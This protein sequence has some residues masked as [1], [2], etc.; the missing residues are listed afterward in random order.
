ML[1]ETLELTQS[2]VKTHQVEKKRQSKLH[3]IETPRR[4]DLVGC[5]SQFKTK[6]KRR[7]AKPDFRGREQIRSDM[8]V[9]PLIK[10]HERLAIRNYMDRQLGG[11][12]S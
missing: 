4:G 9:Y 5:I 6:D 3:S 10:E 11:D 7:L 8:A 12:L 1:A 2:M